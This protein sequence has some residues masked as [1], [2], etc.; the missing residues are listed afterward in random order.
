MRWVLRKLGYLALAFS[1]AQLLACGNDL[2][3]RGTLGTASSSAVTPDQSAQP[4]DGSGAPQE[5]QPTTPD[6][7]TQ[8]PNTI[9]PQPIPPANEVVGNGQLAVKAVAYTTAINPIGFASNIPGFSNL[10]GAN[11]L[12]S[13][14]R[15]SVYV[16]VGW[17][18]IQGA[19]RYRIRRNDT[20]SNDTSDPTQYPV[21]GTVDGRFTGFQDGGGI[22]NNLKVMNEYRY[23][24]E[25]LDSAGNVIATGQD[26]T[27][28]IYPLEIPQLLQPANHATQVGI[29][30]AFGWSTTHGADGYY[31]EVFSTLFGGSPV[32]VPMW[33]TYKPGADNTAAVY[34]TQPNVYPGTAPAMWTMVLNPGAA[35]LWTV[36]AYKTDTGNVQTAKAVAKS[37][38]VPY[39]FTP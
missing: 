25:A 1:C 3:T 18:P 9:D 34:G 12:P 28:A 38:A 30:P 17:R 32:P 13:A 26:N 4:G 5:Q 22:M 10:P 16:I 20:Q 39:M 35:C 15:I 24:V 6:P 33:R 7:T 27:Q 11:L 14:Q 23:V 37:N 21:I 2:P 36:C 29:T 8:G 31:V 19:A